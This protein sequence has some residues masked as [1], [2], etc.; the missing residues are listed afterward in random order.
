[1]CGNHIVVVLKGHQT[2]TTHVGK[3]NILREL[4]VTRCQELKQQPGGVVLQ[5]GFA[6]FPEERATQ[7]G[8]CERLVATCQV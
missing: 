5:C 6:N 7:T 2:E 1:M 3:T 8:Q 4:Y